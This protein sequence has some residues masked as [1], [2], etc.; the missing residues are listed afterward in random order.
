MKAFDNAFTEAIEEY[1]KEFIDV[2]EKHP[3]P[4]VPMLLAAMNEAIKEI[5]VNPSYISDDTKCWYHSI[6]KHLDEN[7]VH[8]TLPC[9]KSVSE[10]KEKMPTNQKYLIAALNDEYDDGG[11]SREAA[12]YYSIACPYSSGDKRCECYGKEPTRDICVICKE[13]WL[14]A[15]V[16]E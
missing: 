14:E 13:K 11:A 16:D 2:I 10:K 8:I 3:K 7:P 12:I 1:A 5:L 6:R 15:E 4:D 9:F